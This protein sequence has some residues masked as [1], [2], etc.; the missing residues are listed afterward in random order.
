MN[1]SNKMQFPKEKI[2]MNWLSEIPNGVRKKT[3]M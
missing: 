1:T 3:V 2:I